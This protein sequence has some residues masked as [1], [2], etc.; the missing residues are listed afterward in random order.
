M[1][2]KYVLSLKVPAAYPVQ[3]LFSVASPFQAP[4]THTSCSSCSSHV[5][6]KCPPELFPL[7]KRLGVNPDTLDGARRPRPAYPA[8]WDPNS[9]HR[10]S[11]SSSD[12][13]DLSP[14]QKSS[15][16]VTL[17]AFISTLSGKPPLH[18]HQPVC[19]FPVLVCL[20]SLSRVSSEW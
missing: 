13:Q 18:P 6:L 19:C 20:M 9:S 2:G 15:L 7:L 1:A 14:G 4:P 11:P 17:C 8:P 12:I 5:D 16:F 10:G 3:L